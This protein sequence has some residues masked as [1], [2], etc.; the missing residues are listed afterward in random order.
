MTSEAQLAATTRDANSTLTAEST[1]QAVV[2]DTY[3]S[4]DVLRLAQVPRPVITADEV[5]V[6]VRTASVHIGDWHMMTGQPYL[7]RVMGFGLRAPKARVR[8]TDLAGTVVAVGKTVTKFHPGEDVY[9]TADGAFAEH[10]SSGLDTLA[11][12]PAN[13]TF[14]Q[15]AAVPTSACT[16]LQALRAGSV[17]AGQQVLIIGA[18]GGVGIFA[19]QI[20]KSFGAEVT[21]VCSTAKVDLV[22]SIGADRA[23]DYTHEDFTRNEQ[24]YD[25]ILDTGGNRTLSELRSALTPKG[26]LVL[27]GGEGGGRWIGGAMGR[28]MRALLLSP[29]VSQQLRMI[30]A[31]ATSDD[32]EFL[33]ELIEAGKVTP[34]IDRTFPLSGAADAIG[35]LAAGHARGKL[36]ITV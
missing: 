12:K 2:Q 8:G 19:V 14:E 20:A 32:L 31:K 34:V 33:T 27:V 23:I 4:A 15:A 3:G 7:M 24:R 17:A 11:P 6:R 30:V 36:V 35:Y 28:S 21:G 25:L 29:F 26:A 22:H 10:A 13:L 18:S 9:G 5:L 16:A 1:M